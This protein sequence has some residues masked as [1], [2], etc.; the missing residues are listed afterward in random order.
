MG[1]SLGVSVGRI[2]EGVGEPGG[3][4]LESTD[5]MEML[6]GAQFKPNVKRSKVRRSLLD[7]YK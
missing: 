4:G 2:W 5:E 6:G 1:V 3:L 7:K